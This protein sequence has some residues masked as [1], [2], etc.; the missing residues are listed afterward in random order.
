MPENG[1]GRMDP[2]F[3]IPRLGCRALGACGDGKRPFAGSVQARN[4]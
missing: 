2:E 3:E 1:S 4:A